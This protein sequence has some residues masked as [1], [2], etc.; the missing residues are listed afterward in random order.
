MH[1]EGIS[2]R[3]REALELDA[4]KK[5]K[6]FG[7]SYCSSDLPLT[8]GYTLTHARVDVADFPDF[9]KLVHVHTL[10]A[11]DVGLGKSSNCQR[12]EYAVL[13]ELDALD[14]PHGRV[15]VIGDVHGMN[16]SLQ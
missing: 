15:A 5:Q 11:A 4:S 2:S 9:D 13:I 1:P 10:H 6:V 14:N 7:T 8:L 16:H 12:R 3:S